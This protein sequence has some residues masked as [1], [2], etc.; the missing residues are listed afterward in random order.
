[1]RNVILGIAIAFCMALGGLSAASAAPVGGSASGTAA[2]ADTALHKV[3]SAG[4]CARLKRACDYKEERG[5]E[6]QGNCRRYRIECGRF[7]YCQALR[8]ACIY[9][10]ER[11][12]EGRGNCRRYRSECGEYD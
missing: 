3:V 6:G 4:Y 11:G 8:R 2:F 1:M 10:E 7:N 9:K 12:Q 5:E